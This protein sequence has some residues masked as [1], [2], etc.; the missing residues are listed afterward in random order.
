MQIDD[1][2]NTGSTPVVMHE[3]IARVSDKLAGKTAA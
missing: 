3:I 2:T 1:G